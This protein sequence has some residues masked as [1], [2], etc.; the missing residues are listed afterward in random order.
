M[1]VEEKENDKK[2]LFTDLQFDSLTHQIAFYT[3]YFFCSVEPYNQS[4]TFLLSLSLA[5]TTGFLAPIFPS[6]ESEQKSCRA[7]RSVPMFDADYL[8]M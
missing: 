1:A 5:H 6:R 2:H 7:P 8:V 3:F 4:H